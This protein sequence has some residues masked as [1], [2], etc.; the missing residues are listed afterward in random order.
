MRTP[1]DLPARAPRAKGR[2]RWW[3][4]GAVVVLVVILASLKS[5]ATL[6][7]DSLWFSSVQLHN[8]WSTLLAVK[9]G[10]FASF[11][12][13]FFVGLWVNL[14]VCDRIGIRTAT[15]EPDDELVRRYQQAVRPYSRRI[16]AAISF[17]FALIAASGTVGEWN[18]WILFTHA[19]S[20]GVKDPQFG[21]D[22]GFFVF[23]LP[24]LQFLVD[25]GL[26]VLVVM[27][28]VTAIFHYLNGGIRAQRTPPR[29]R[30][31]VKVHLSVL[32][33]LIA[34][35]KAAGYVL[36]RFQLDTSTNG[37]VE[38]VGYT[39]AHARLPALEVLFFISLFAAA[40]LLYNIRRQGWTL[41]VLAIG[42]WAFVALVIGVIYPAVLQVLKVNPAQSTLEQPYIKRNIAATRAAYGVTHVKQ[43][44]FEG[45]TT[46]S[47]NTVADNAT[48]LANIRLWDP[49]PSISLPTFQKLQGLRSYYQFQTV[50]IDRYT[51][52]G[53]LRPA[54]VGVRQ[55]NPND[56]P[57]TSWVNTHLQYTHGEGIAL[58]QANQTTS[59]G[60]P[61][62]SIKDI[63]P[64]SS[65]GLPKITQPDVYFGLNDPGYVVADSKQAELDYQKD[66]GVDV[67]THYQ[68]TGGVKMGSFFTKAAFA[69]RLGDFNLLISDL[70][71]PQSRIMF[72][73]TVVGMAQKAAPFLSF[74]NDPYSAVVDGHIDWIL[75]AYTTTAEYPYSQNADT[76]QVPPGSGLPGSYNYVRNSVKVVIDAYN[77]SMTFYA[78]D[79]DPILRAYES[80][81]PHM[82]TPASAMPEALAAH[83]RYPEDLFSAQAAVYGRYHITSPSNFYTA[84]DAWNLSPT[85]GV[86]SPSNAL[87]VTVTTNAQGQVTGGAPQ[88]MSPLY[89]VLEQP[90]QQ[91]QSFT[92][93]DAYVPASQGASIQ[94]L[95]AFMMAGSDPGQY[96]QLRV[97]VTTPGHS[98]VGPAL[99]DS[100]I[101]QSSTV[102]QKISLLD[103]H[104][105]QVVLGNILMVPIDQSMLYIRPL[106][107]ES[108]GNP[109]PQ[110]KYVIAVFG[111]KVGMETSLDASLNKVLGTH[112]GTATSA[113]G[114]NSSQPTPGTNPAASSAVAQAQQ[115]LQQAALDY[116]KAQTD[117]KAGNL[118]TYQND[119]AAEH[120]EET[121]AKSLL[122]STGSPT[123]TTTAPSS[124]SPSKS[125]SKAGATTTTTAAKGTGS[126]T[127]A[128]HKAASTGGA[129]SSTTSTTGLSSKA[130]TGTVG[131]SKGSAS[132]GS[133]GTSSTTTTSTTTS[134][135]E[136]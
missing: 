133:S 56:L 63:P 76:Q 17:V 93:S 74:D 130:S 129:A 57:S 122:G 41:P 128:N 46:V 91:T 78:M 83:L 79:N 8:V 104:G 10:L 24:F 25:W 19:Q 102:S 9:V 85:A 14:V 60:N 81:F 121:A 5:L 23:R 13:I 1:Q 30:P 36:Q 71:T 94:N 126:G 117:L 103:Q 49:D 116:A 58:A 43:V 27:L 98:V 136:A 107:T 44:P 68:G 77:G 108:T 132:N 97:Y 33:A 12:A 88:R 59:N 127:T 18:N 64:V 131:G 80:A 111:Q 22:V 95:S 39:D 35:V 37:Y 134:A 54:L 29:V 124:T 120:A 28:V 84:G 113:T 106:Y 26:I 52:G 105:S 96:G 53:T 86:G 112:L 47:A 20:F 55:L 3:I 87:A 69:V 67:E 65:K 135:N 7:T 11:G 92:I 50:G 2:A 16:Y 51:V 42:I 99:A 62:F 110:L 89:Q 48:T 125:S 31:A 123:T 40:I 34:L 118:G 38:G 73:R 101:Q 45:N 100:Y 72:V 21:M 61:V 15:L 75:D 109:Q 70:I 82:F 4:I 66:T 32:L 6:Y 119:I 90:G 114:T 115:D